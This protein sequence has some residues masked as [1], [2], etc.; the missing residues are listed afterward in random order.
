MLETLANDLRLSSLRGS[1]RGLV[2]PK[3]LFRPGSQN[4]A[5]RGV[6][7][8]RRGIG[9]GRPLGDAIGVFL[10]EFVRLR[11][12]FPS[13]LSQTV[14]PWGWI[15]SSRVIGVGRSLCPT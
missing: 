3:Q 14:L 15:G 2:A 5:G 10:I 4:C 13:A 7:F 6:R 1:Q 9:V 8:S 12:H 11:I